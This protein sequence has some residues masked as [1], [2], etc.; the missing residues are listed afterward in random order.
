MA[1]VSGEVRGVGRGV[2]VAGA[3]AANGTANDSAAAAMAW[4]L[5]A[6]EG[7]ASTCSAASSSRVRPATSKRL[8]PF[9]RPASVWRPAP[10]MIGILLG[11]GVGYGGL[12]ELS[13]VVV[14]VLKV[15]SN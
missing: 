10:L 2:S 4:R 13:E 1:V 14:G 9:G 7:L 11:I 15:K 5:A 8:A 12:K 3:G 6:V